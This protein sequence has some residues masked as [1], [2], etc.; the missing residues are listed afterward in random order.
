MQAA[1]RN[2]SFDS[3]HSQGSSCL[4][5]LPVSVHRAEQGKDMMLAQR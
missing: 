5:A 1:S 3:L 2:C 4:S